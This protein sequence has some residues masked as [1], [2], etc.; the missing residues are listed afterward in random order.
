MNLEFKVGRWYWVKNSE[1]IQFRGQLI[2]NECGHVVMCDGIGTVF[3]ATK[4]RVICEAE[5]RPTYPSE[6]LI[7]LLLFFLT[8]L[9]GRWYQKN[10]G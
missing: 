5:S 2:R 7:A 6:F 8:F 10:Y 1:A 4:D 3:T 9:W